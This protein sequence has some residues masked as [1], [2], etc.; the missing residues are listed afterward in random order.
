MALI[1]GTTGPERTV[2]MR[3]FI[4]TT[5]PLLVAVSFL[6][7]LFVFSTAQPLPSFSEPAVFVSPFPKMNRNVTTI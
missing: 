4:L 2:Q 6:P 7:P 1:Q 3:L 5:L